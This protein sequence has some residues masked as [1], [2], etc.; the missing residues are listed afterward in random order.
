[1]SA[2]AGQIRQRYDQLAPWSGLAQSPGDAEIDSLEAELTA[3]APVDGA[4]RA[5]LSEAVELISRLRA[6]AALR[7]NRP[8]ALRGEVGAPGQDLRPAVADPVAG[9]QPRSDQLS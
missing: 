5:A 2:L 8:P 4:D 3:L 1:M 9:G 7:V 6:L